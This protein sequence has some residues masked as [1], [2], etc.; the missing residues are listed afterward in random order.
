MTPREGEGEGCIA[1]VVI[2]ERRFTARCE[3][4]VWAAFDAGRQIEEFRIV[5]VVSER[6]LKQI[7]SKF[8]W[9]SNH[10]TQL[11]LVCL[12]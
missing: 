2:Q 7:N 12:M 4:L 1:R 6:E 11:H 8:T 10:Y 3:R 5:P 9:A